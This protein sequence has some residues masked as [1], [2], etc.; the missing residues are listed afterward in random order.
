MTLKGNNAYRRAGGLDVHGG[1]RPPRASEPHGPLTSEGG[2]GA[3]AGPR[4]PSTTLRTDLKGK[5]T[6][7]TPFPSDLRELE[8]LRSTVD[9]SH[10]RGFKTTRVSFREGRRKEGKGDRRGGRRKGLRRKPNQG[11]KTYEHHDHS[12]SSNPR[13]RIFTWE[14]SGPL[15]RPVKL[16]YTS[17]A[18]TSLISLL[19]SKPRPPVETSSRTGGRLKSKKRE[20]LFSLVNK[21]TRPRPTPRLRFLSQF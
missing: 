13:R 19:V 5:R 21:G 9:G 20:N 7:H 10:S 4:R 3:S 1:G 8:G 15:Q 14:K 17:Y 2:P 11:R 12:K 6:P 16:C 18:N